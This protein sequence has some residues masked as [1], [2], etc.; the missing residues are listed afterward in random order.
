MKSF[1]FWSFIC[2]ISCVLLWVP[3]VVFQVASPLFLLTFIIGPVGM[4]FALIKKH[5]FLAVLNLIGTL[6][7]YILMFLGYWWYSL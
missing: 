3:N 1:K 5:F 2:F 4:V 6:S 7:F